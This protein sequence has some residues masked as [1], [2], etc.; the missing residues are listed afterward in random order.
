MCLH[1]VD[2]NRYYVGMFIDQLPPVPSGEHIAYERRYSIGAQVVVCDFMSEISQLLG[3]QLM[4][5]PYDQSA[6]RLATL[7]HNG[8]YLQARESVV[9]AEPDSYMHTGARQMGLSSKTFRDKFGNPRH[10]PNPDF[11]LATHFLGNPEKSTVFDPIELNPLLDLNRENLATY[12]V[13]RVRP[14]VSYQADKFDIREAVLYTARD[15]EYWL[16]E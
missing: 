5:S 11:V 2:K 3:E 13:D 7:L 15:S 6:K 14:A 4:D 12:Y 8:K 9:T 10:D 16:G 1:T